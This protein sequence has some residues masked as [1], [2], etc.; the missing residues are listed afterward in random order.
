MAVVVTYNPNIFSIFQTFYTLREVDLIESLAYLTN[1][2]KSMGTSQEQG[3]LITYLA[4]F[5]FTAIQLLE[6]EFNS[7]WTYLD[8]LT[9]DEYD[10]II[11]KLELAQATP[12]IIN[13]PGLLPGAVPIA[14]SS[15]EYHE[16]ITRPIT[17]I[18]SEDTPTI[19]PLSLATEDKPYS[20][21]I[22]HSDGT[23]ITDKVA[24]QLILNAGFWELYLYSIETLNNVELK[25]MY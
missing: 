5:Y 22:I 20:I 9:Q 4:Q 13:V 7:E 21:M 14:P 25:I 15:S 24:P 17:I 1:D 2:E 18:G 3:T 10:K 23:I 16:P 19:I 6:L 8:W 11:Y 12:N